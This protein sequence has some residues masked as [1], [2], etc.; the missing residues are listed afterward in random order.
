MARQRAADRHRR[1]IG[2]ADLAEHDDVGVLTQKGAQRSAEGQADLLLELHL[3]HPFERILDRVLDRKDVARLAVQP[4]ERRVERRAL[5]RAGRSGDQ[6]HAVRAR[7]GRLVVGEL[8]LRETE[9]RELQ[10]FGMARQQAQHDFLSVDRRKRRDT[11]V[12]LA[13]APVVEDAPVLRQTALRNIQVRHNLD[14]VDDRGVVAPI[15]HVLLYKLAVD[16]QADAT[17]LLV[18]LE[19]DIARILVERLA[20]QIRQKSLSAADLA[21]IR[22]PVRRGAGLLPA[23]VAVQQQ[24]ELVR[25]DRF[26]LYPESGQHLDLLRHGSV[27]AP[28][29]SGA[30][31]G[32]ILTGVRYEP[33]TPCLGGGKQLH[34]L[35]RYALRKG[36]GSEM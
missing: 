19:M 27:V 10:Q 23:V 5:A 4:P 21:P 30:Q 22:R 28:P 2:V 33:V 26:D 1:R 11:Q 35:G 13:L 9:V 14:L 8:P 18:G 29:L 6:R 7:D 12:E 36:H 17:A 31:H 15:E 16:A 24:G 34:D 3:V 20:D 25:P 32:S